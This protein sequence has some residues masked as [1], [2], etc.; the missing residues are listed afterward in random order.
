MR[1]LMKDIRLI[2]FDWSSTVFSPSHIYNSALTTTPSESPSP[3]SAYHGPPPNSIL[4]VS[5]PTSV[6][7]PNPSLHESQVFSPYSPSVGVRQVSHCYPVSFIDHIC[8]FHCVDQAGLICTLS[9]FVIHSHKYSSI[10][11]SIIILRMDHTLPSKLKCINWKCPP[12]HRASP[13]F[14][15]QETRHRYLIHQPC[16]IQLYWLLPST[17]AIHPIIRTFG[18]QWTTTIAIRI[19]IRPTTTMT[20]FSLVYPFQMTKV[21]GKSWFFALAHCPYSVLS[22]HINIYTNTHTQTYTQ[23][24]V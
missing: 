4:P 6:A 7:I 22:A 21:Y 24:E 19:V 10:H 18:P 20:E 1:L 14:W 11:F 9:L 17:M 3:R 8:L 16:C 12:V 15:I 13:A 2:E 23:I 5:L